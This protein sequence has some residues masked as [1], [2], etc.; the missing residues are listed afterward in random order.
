LLPLSR[1]SGVEFYYLQF[2]GHQCYLTS[3]IEYQTH[4]ENAKPHLV[5][6]HYTDL[7]S[8]K[9][10]V[11]MMGELDPDVKTL[12]LQE[13]LQLTFAV[14]EFYVSGP[15]EKQDLLRLFHENPSQFDYKRLAEVGA[16]IG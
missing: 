7:L 15:P 1:E 4:G 6:T 9:G 11:L 8:S 12:D 3:L 5:L 13:A 2:H 10:I 14:Q 16:K